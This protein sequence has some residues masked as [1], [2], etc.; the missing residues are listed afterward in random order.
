MRWI[1]IFLILTALPF[2]A[3]CRL[4]LQTQGAGLILGENSRQLY[5]KGHVLD[6][7]EDFDEQFQ[8]IPAPGR[9]FLRWHTLCENVNGACEVVLRREAWEQDVDVTLTAQFRPNYNG[10]LRL[11]DYDLWWYPQ[12]REFG[13]PVDS[14][15]IS[16]LAPSGPVEVFMASQDMRRVIRARRRGDEYRFPLNENDD[17]ED[18]WPFITARDSEGNIASVS[19]DFD[20]AEFDGTPLQAHNASSPWANVLARC[21]T[22]NSPFEVCPFQKLPLLGTR[23]E[24]P[25]VTD[26]MMRTVVSHPWMGR[27]FREVLQEMPPEMLKMFRSVSAVVISSEV[28][29]SFYLT[30]TGAIYLDPDDL[31]L[32]PAERASISTEPD[33]REEYASVFALSP[34]W[35]YMQGDTEAWI[36]S[37]EWPANSQ[38]R[39]EDILLPMATLLLHELT[40]A[41]DGIPAEFLHQ[42]VGTYTPLEIS[43]RIYN[44]TPTN[45]LYGSYPLYSRLMY[46]LAASLFYGEEASIEILSLSARDAGLE[47]SNHAA[48]DLYAYAS[49]WEDTAMLVEEVLSHHFF[50]VERI[51]AF[52]D[53]PGDREDLDCND[54]VLRWGDRNRVF[55]STVRQRAEL[56]LRQVLDE[57]DLS[58]Y[59]DNAPRHR[60]LRA[61]SGVCDYFDVLGFDESVRGRSVS[62]PQRVTEQLQRSRLHGDIRSG[63][64]SIRRKQHADY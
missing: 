29:P 9:S 60:G 34:F 21:A 12:S 3:S 37:G 17:R 56:V 63:F 46:D 15:L 48:N 42:A 24:I 62:I 40:H 11:L 36:P 47:F 26:I 58:T 27:R 55:K 44:Y 6:I 13:L 7:N 31:W 16:G 54:F 32:T 25:D 8:P 50:G 4:E 57:A 49:G 5:R 33:Y 23:T 18:F 1:R 64:E 51:V 14:L 22:A 2:L 20:M 52:L 53:D 35:L 61:G 38:R 30:A 59:L 10:P 28:R 43:N 39:I 41:A 19:V 45:Q